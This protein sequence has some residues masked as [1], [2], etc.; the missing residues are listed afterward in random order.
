[1]ARRL[2]GSPSEPRRGA[3]ATSPEARE[4]QMVNLAFD[5]AERQIMEGKA[6]S[7]VLT[8]FLKLGSE[9]EK[10]EREKLRLE[11]QHLQIKSEQ[12]AQGARMEEL[13]EKAISA[14]HEYS[15]KEP[16]EEDAEDDY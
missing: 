16:G 9:R 4:L 2:E 14:F 1:M 5:E 8:H 3:P 6:S 10:L 12:L 7:Q 13:Y 11:A 15:G